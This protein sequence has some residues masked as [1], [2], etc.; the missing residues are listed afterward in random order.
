M[1]TFLKGYR[2]HQTLFL[3]NCAHTTTVHIPIPEALKRELQTWGKCLVDN[4]QGFPVPI[5][6][7]FP[8]LYPRTFV[9]DAAGAGLTHQ[10]PHGA[11]VPAPGDRG[12]ASLGYNN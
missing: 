6:A 11:G 10:V 9:S 12:V 3:Q 5:Q 2:F 1:C 8:P 4:A 7:E